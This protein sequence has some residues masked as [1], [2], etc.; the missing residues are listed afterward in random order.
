MTSENQEW[1]LH[2]LDPGIR[3]ALDAPK[4]GVSPYAF[5]QRVYDAAWDWR[6]KTEHSLANEGEWY[7]V[8]SIMHQASAI[9]WSMLA[10]AERYPELREEYL[11]R[12]A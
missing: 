8:E 2:R 3:A 11:G 9:K 12:K 6:M 4:E 5:W 1:A 7:L 10:M